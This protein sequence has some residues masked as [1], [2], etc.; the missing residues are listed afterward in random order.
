MHWTEIF[1]AELAKSPNVTGAARAAGIDRTTAYARAKVDPEFAAAWED[2]QEQSTDA[3]VGEAYRRAHQGTEKPVFYE[4]AECG[5]IREYSDTLAIFLLKTHRPH[6]YG[7]RLRQEITG[8]NGGP[9]EFLA[10]IDH[11]YGD[12]AGG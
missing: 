8:A 5:R 6:V 3:L 4:G 1:L 10:G 7:D 9:L 2:A 12:K 11:A